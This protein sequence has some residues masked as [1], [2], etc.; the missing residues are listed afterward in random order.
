MERNFFNS[1]ILQKEFL[2]EKEC[3]EGNLGVTSRNI[4]GC[5]WYINSLEDHYCFWKWV[6]RRSDSDGDMTPLANKEIPKLLKIPA[7]N[8][9]QLVME[10]LENLKK[11]EDFEDLKLFFQTT[12]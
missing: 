5:P 6:Q 2:P 7:S 10:A 9:N 4:Q 8:A 11:T 12:E 3:P 1:C